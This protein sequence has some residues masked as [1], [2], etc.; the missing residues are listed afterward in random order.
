MKGLQ[1]PQTISFGSTGKRSQ[2]NL[3]SPPPAEHISYKPEMVDEQ[4]GWVKILSPEKRWNKKMNHCYVLTICTGCNSIQWQ[5]LNNLKSGKSRG[6]QR[7]SQPR[8][9]PKWLDKRLS[10]AKRRCENPRSPGYANYGGRG[11]KFGF[12][13]VLDAGLYLI[14]T[15]GL[16]SRSMEIDRI[17]ANGDYAPGNLRFV[18]HRVNCVNQRRSVLSDFSPEY[19]PYSYTVVIRK[20]SQGLTRSEIIHDAERAVF[21]KRKNWRLISARLDFMT[22]EMPETITVLPYRGTSSTTAATADPLVH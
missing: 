17:D 16:P 21:E 2:Y 6:C 12:Q 11:I 1:Q 10:A 18:G 5:N 9:I 13:S 4:Y 22:Y 14:E 19:W 20:L 15:Y 8:K 7:C 3:E